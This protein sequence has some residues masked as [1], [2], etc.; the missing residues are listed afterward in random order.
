MSATKEPCLGGKKKS[1]LT[2]KRVSTAVRVRDLRFSPDVVTTH[3]MSREICTGGG[4]DRGKRCTKGEEK[5]KERR[6]RL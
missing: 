3:C 1:L 6:Q 4:K 5:E 2:N